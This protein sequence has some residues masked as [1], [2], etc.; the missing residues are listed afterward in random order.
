MR[1]SPFASYHP[2]IVFSFFVGAIIL[3]VLGF[4]PAFQA[5]GLICA[6]AYYLC[7]RGQSGWKVIFGLI[8]VF[9]VLT[10]VN[11]L[12]NTQGETVLFTWFGGRPYTLQAL[13]Y[14]ASTACM[15]VS[16]LL[17]FFC[18]NHVVTSDK[19]TYLFGSFAPALTLVFTMVLRLVPTYQRKAQE[20][21]GARDCV[22]HSISKGS[23]QER[24]KAGTSLL[25]ALTTWALEGAIITAD[26]MRSR[27]YG[28]GK[29]TTFASYRWTLCDKI[30][31]V[32]MVALGAV[33]LIA[34]LW[35][36]PSAQYFPS[37][38]FPPLSPFSW[39]GFGAFTLFLAL[40]TL[41]DLQE[42]ALW[43]ISLSKI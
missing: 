32:G 40:P 21:I 36:L 17:W 19:F 30:L 18:Y 16:I 27:G 3:C 41:I 1:Y 29:R 38:D 31:L 43:R 33:S 34:I 12:F 5:V 4:N 13:A 20:I 37:F 2:V 10:A 26:S 6:I 14:G 11:P 15:F 7:V 25:S 39:V 42:A 8:P 24:V 35:A 9:L 22:G 28:T 23:V